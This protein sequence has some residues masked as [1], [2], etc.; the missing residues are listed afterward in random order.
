DGQLRLVAVEYASWQP[1][2]LFG[3]TFAPPA[4]IGEPGPPFYTLHAWIWQGNPDGVFAPFNPNVTC[5]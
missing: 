3:Q 5:D 4:G 1:A 2:S